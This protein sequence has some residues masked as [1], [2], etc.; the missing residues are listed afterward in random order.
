MVWAEIPDE[1]RYPELN[2]KVLKHMIHGPCG[3]P[4]M[5]YP[6]TGE[7]G[8]CLKGFDCA[9]IEVQARDGTRFIRI[10]EVNS[11]LNA[12]YVSAPEAMWRLNGYDLFMKSHTVIRLAVHLP[13][14]Q[15]VYFRAGNEEQAAQ[16]EL[17]RDTTLTAW[18]KLNQS[19]ENAVQFL[20]TDIPYHYVYD[21]KET[22]W[23][24]R[25]KGG[26]KIISRLYTVSIKDIER[27]YLRLLLLHVAGA[28]CFKDLKTVNGVVYE[29]F[30]DAA[31]AKNLVETDDLWGKTLE[32]AIESKMPVQFRELFSYICIFGTPIDV[33][34]IWNK[35]KDFLIEDFVHKN[36]VNPENMALNHIQEILINNGSSCENFQ[37]PNPTP[38]NIYITEYN[39][40][41]ERIRGDYLLSTLNAEQK[42]VYDIVMRAIEN[43]NELHRLFFIDGF[44]GSGKTYLFNTFLSVIRGRNEIV[45]PCASTGIA[46]TLLKGGRTYHSLFKLSIPIDDSVKSNIRGN[47]Q[48]ARE[49]IIAKLIIWDEVSM[50]VGHALTAVDK[51]LRDLMKNPRPFGGKVILFAGDFRQNLPVV[52]HAQ[53][54]AI[55]ESTVKYSSIWRNV[56][57][58]K[59]KQNMRTGEEKEFANWLMQLGDGK[60]SN[61]D[62]LHLDTIEI[63]QNFIS[64]ES[65]IA[66]IF[67][68]RITMEQ[69]KENPDRTI[70]CPKNEDTFKIN[71]EILCLMEGEEKEY[72]SIDSIVSDDPQEQLN[73]PTE[74]LNSLTPSGMPVHRLKIKG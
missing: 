3:D 60:L 7:D 48:A 59:L 16:R 71:D 27:F 70:L 22:K 18:L 8:K 68:D 1:E 20:Y 67:G 73:F 31:I 63:P 17:N 62:G 39:V 19:D 30:K 29:T 56:T 13:N 44:A 10:D 47:S 12:R 35:Y 40:D 23:K 14:R 28:K 32:E 74:F 65:L 49:L 51:L 25:K 41:E 4:S 37:L 50:T 61:T 5:R 42:H 11:F 52:P 66:E 2:E 34:A 43:Q 24:P 46:A 55:I 15:M 64:K 69:I 26:D 38:V 57:Q 36:V 58:V 54:A 21:K 45:L 53:K 33:L 9:A 72:L 6:C